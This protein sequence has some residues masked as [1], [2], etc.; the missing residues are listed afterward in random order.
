MRGTDRVIFC[1][2]SERE[3]HRLKTVSGRGRGKCI[4]EQTGGKAYEYSCTETH[5]TCIE[6]KAGCLSVE[7]NRG[8]LR[9]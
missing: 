4:R 3:R 1:K 9:L 7:W 5:V 2:P 6:W 8:Y